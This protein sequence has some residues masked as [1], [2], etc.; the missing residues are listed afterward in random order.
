[1]TTP[2]RPSAPSAGAR[3]SEQFADLPPL[4]QVERLRTVY[5]LT[6]D[7]S[8]ARGLDEIYEA[9]LHGLERALATERASILLF[10]PDDVMRFKAW[11]GLSDEYRRAVEGHS[12]WT[13]DTVD[14]QPV[15]VADIEQEESLRAFGD[16]FRAEGI[17][18]LG[19]IPL[20]SRGRLIGKFM[21]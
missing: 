8:R 12:P 7:V 6:D 2:K 20:L 5:R 10:D 1:M 16:I 18:A 21:V 9:A 19:F 3:D 15:V 13:R 17:R 14:P 11:H 4:W